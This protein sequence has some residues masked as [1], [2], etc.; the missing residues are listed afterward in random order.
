MEVRISRLERGPDLAIALGGPDARALDAGKLVPEARDVE[1]E[2][3]LEDGPVAVLVA[4]RGVGALEGLFHGAATITDG[5]DF[6]E[7]DFEEAAGLGDGG[8]DRVAPAG[9]GTASADQVFGA[10][11]LD[12]VERG[13][14]PLAVPGVAGVERGLRFDEVAGEENLG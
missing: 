10:E 6:A 3:V 12:A 8:V 13:G 9:Y 11:G 2:A 14:G 4:Q 7:H 5:A 1:G